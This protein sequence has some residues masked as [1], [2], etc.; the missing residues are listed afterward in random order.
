MWR[1]MPFEQLDA[2]R[3]SHRLA[4]AVY[5]LTEAWPVSE[6][7]GDYRAVDGQMVPFL[8]TVKDEE[9]GTVVI[10]VKEAAFNVPVSDGEF[11]R[12]N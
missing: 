8:T 11:R 7:Y 12:K 9:S 4:L 5:E 10:R 1:M 6:R 2:W 3:S